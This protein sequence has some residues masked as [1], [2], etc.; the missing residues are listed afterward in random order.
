MKIRQTD[1]DLRNH[2]FEQIQFLLRSNFLYDNGFI[3]E[4][5]RMSIIIRLLLHDTDRSV[6]LLSQMNINNMLF[7]DTSHDYNEYNLS[8]TLG[9]IL[10]RTSVNPT[11]A[12]F[13]PALDDREEYKNRR[14]SFE[15]WWN[16]IVLADMSKNIFTRRDLILS[17]VNKDGGAHIDPKLD[18]PYGELTRRKTLGLKFI[19]NDSEIKHGIEPIYA[20]I[21]QISHETLKSLKD[22]FP[23]FVQM[24]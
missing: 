16:K 14:I 4:A 9:L 10:I 19:V 7:Y 6:S 12:K 1:D 2:L 23:D 20:S 5:K 21:R 15:K 18:K 17:I 13:I 22:E 3:N 8:P 11:F 24:T